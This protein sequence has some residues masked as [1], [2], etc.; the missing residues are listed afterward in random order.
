MTARVQDDPPAITINWI[1]D[2]RAIKYDLYRRVYGAENWGAKIGTYAADVIQYMDSEVVINT[3]YEYKIQ[4]YTE[5]NVDGFGYI[6]SAIQLDPVHDNGEVL[7]VITER[8]HAEVKNTL[9]EYRQILSQDGWMNRLLVIPDGLISGEVK[10]LI[11]SQYLL[12]PFDACLILGDVPVPQSGDIYPDAHTEHKGAWAADIF[13]GDI[14]GLW[15]D[16]LVN[17]ISALHAVNHNMP[18][19]GRWDQS[20]IPSDVEVAVG[21]VDFSNLPVFAQ[22]EFEL[23]RKYL[24]KNIAYRTK[25]FEVPRRAAMRNINPWIGALG[26]NG[27]RNFSP[28]VGAENISYGEIKP[29]WQEPYL[30]F[31]G[32]SS[33]NHDISFLISSSAEFAS[34][35]LQAIFTAWFGSWFG[36]YNFENNYLRS[37][38]GSGT[39][40][41]S[42]WVGAPH[43]HFHSM[44]MG[45]SLGHATKV[46][47]NNDTIY[48]A[49]SFPRGV[50]V[51]LLGDPTLRLFPVMPARS[52]NI[53]EMEKHIFLR[54]NESPDADGYHVYRKKVNE[55]SYTLLNDK[56]SADLEFR[57]SCL[58][59][60]STYDYLVRAV[61]LETTPSGQYFNLSTGVHASIRSTIP[62]I[63]V[64]DIRIDQSDDFVFHNTSSNADSF[65]WILPDGSTLSDS[66]LSV[67]RNLTG[68]IVLIAQNTCG[69]DTLTHELLVTN[70]DQKVPPTLSIQPNPATSEIKITAQADITYIRLVSHLGQEMISYPVAKSKIYHL[71][72]EEYQ[73]GYYFLL[74]SAGDSVFHRPLLL[75][76]DN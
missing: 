50:H 17:N 49:D 46:S 51:N 14:D 54:W 47:Q 1:Q 37:A 35:S 55:G 26:Q 3:L 66:S 43:W 58:E 62:Y 27:I 11:K 38:L 32:A 13:Y 6:L 2:P 40:L 76:T 20:T 57:D 22:D 33:G 63:P 29:V 12:R 4:K 8:T 21:R 48:T 7:L 16:S 75:L 24:K 23:L 74:V 72:I 71:N 25:A 61:K 9:E 68:E 45:F 42:A 56:I 28:I 59:Q 64:A 19:D 10:P 52:L 34:D 31:Y 41:S 15:T 67:P 5:E 53:E 70:T 30:W 69:A 73:S 60:D 18:G 65:R 44:A 39:V 36:D